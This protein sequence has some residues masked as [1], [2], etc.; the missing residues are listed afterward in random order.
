MASKITA[1]LTLIKKLPEK[2]TSRKLTVDGTVY[3]FTEGGSVS[4]IPINMAEHAVLVN[5]GVFKITG[6]SVKDPETEKLKDM[7]SKAKNLNELKKQ[8]GFKTED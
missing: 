6:T 2:A 4:G 7:V 3:E 5:P 8:L 1:T